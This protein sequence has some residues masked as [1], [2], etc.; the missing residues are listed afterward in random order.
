[1]NTAI[2]TLKLSTTEEKDRLTLLLTGTAEFKTPE[3]LLG[4]LVTVHKRAIELSAKE[5]RIDLGGVDFMNSTGLGALVGLIGERQKDAKS[6]Y[7][8][9][10]VGNSARRWQ[11]ASLHSLASFAPETIT[12]SFAP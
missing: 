11:R 4:A 3:Q 6:R 2:D 10:L 7:I 8:I 5:L 12:V 1:M 9:H